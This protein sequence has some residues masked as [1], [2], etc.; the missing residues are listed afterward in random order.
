MKN[1]YK[2]VSDFGANNSPATHPLTYCI[3]SNMNQQFLHGGNPYGS[4]SKHCQSFMAD[5]C[6]SGWDGFCEIESKNT[7][8]SLVPSGKGL[9]DYKTAGDVLIANTANRKYL[10]NI[11]NATEMYEP[12][13]PTVADSPMIRYWINKGS[14]PQVFEHAV[15]PS[16]ID[17]DVLMDKILENPD[18]AFGILSSI[19]KT[20]KRKDT[21][22]FLKNTKLGAFYN[23]HPYF[24]KMGGVNS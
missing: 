6:A 1:S 17:K 10:I 16:I 5:Y 24:K 20:M 12:F 19:Y 4:K 14:G 11:E 23:Y 21:L 8:M 9:L 3:G 13:D 7:D 15:D 2:S 18:L 22:K